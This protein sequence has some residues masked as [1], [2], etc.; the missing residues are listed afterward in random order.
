MLTHANVQIHLGFVVFTPLLIV[1]GQFEKA[2]DIYE[3]AINSVTTVRDFTIV[4]DAY[5]KVPVIGSPVVL[6]VDCMWSFTSFLVLFW[7]PGGL[8]GFSVCCVISLHHSLKNSL[9]VRLTFIS[10]TFQ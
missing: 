6:V 9:C 4:F 2:R 3:E 5:V 1:A 10:L 7:S 8:P